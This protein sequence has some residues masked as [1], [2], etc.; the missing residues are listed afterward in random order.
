MMT[1]SVPFSRNQNSR[2]N[3]AFPSEF[4]QNFEIR[5]E[6]S[7]KQFTSPTPSSC[8]RIKILVR[9]LLSHQNFLTILIFFV[10]LVSNRSHRGHDPLVSES[11]FS[12]E[13]CFSTRIFS[14]FSYS[15][16]ILSQTVIITDTVPL[17]RNQNSPSNFAFPSE[18]GH[19]SDILWEFCLKQISSPTPS[20]CLQ[21][22]ILL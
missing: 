15:M 22:K 10:N 14:Q 21:I 5:W 3:F 1:E 12:F 19:N 2:S 7:L 16:G 8:L 6:F 18:F 4:C 11:K 13:F 9:I 20:P 17:F